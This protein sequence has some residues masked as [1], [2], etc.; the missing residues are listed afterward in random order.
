MLDTM[1]NVR[2]KQTGVYFPNE[3]TN[4]APQGIVYTSQMRHPRKNVP[5]DQIDT[6][7][8]ISRFWNACELCIN[9]Q[10]QRFTV[11]NSL[12]NRLHIADVRSLFGFVF[13]EV[14]TPFVGVIKKN[15]V[16]DHRLN[17]HVLLFINVAQRLR[18]NQR[19]HIVKQ[20]TSSI[21]TPK[22]LLKKI[23]IVKAA[24]TCS[25]I[26]RYLLEKKQPLQFP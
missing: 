13:L 2:R 8:D 14:A 1:N 7:L 26:F 17:L 20:V 4:Q 5:T 12:P 22:N 25:K 16:I 11:Y 3:C 24:R 21:V 6:I 19:I 18:A 23:G 9:L 15:Q 10:L